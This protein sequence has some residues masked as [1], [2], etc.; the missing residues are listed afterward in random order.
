MKKHIII[1]IAI[2][3]AGC[4]AAL[5]QDI[6]GVSVDTE[7]TVRKTTSKT[8]QNKGFCL[9]GDIDYKSIVDRLGVPAEFTSLEESRKTPMFGNTAEPRYASA[10]YDK[11]G[12]SD[13]IDFADNRLDGF[14]LR[15]DRFAAFSHIFAGGLRVGDPE[16]RITDALKYGDSKWDPSRDRF[17]YKRILTKAEDD[18]ETTPNII[19]LDGSNDSCIMAVRVEQ[20]SVTL[21]VC[22]TRD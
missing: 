4:S 3:L 18:D 2:A 19:L 7:F 5:A 6:D 22:T 14:D 20:G 9:K 12:Q 15:T 1:T 11:D 17:A 8:A 21:I 13:Y 10:R 16:K